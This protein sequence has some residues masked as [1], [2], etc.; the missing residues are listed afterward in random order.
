MPG[1]A[2]M[3]FPELYKK[4]IDS[5]YLAS[6]D[7]VHHLNA[8]EEERNQGR[9]NFEAVVKARERGEHVT[10]LVLLTL[11][12]RTD[13]KVNRESSP[14]GLHGELPDL[15]LH[16]V[17]RQIFRIRGHLSRVGRPGLKVPGWVE[18]R[19][20]RSSRRRGGHGVNHRGRDRSR[21]ALLLERE[22]AWILH[23]RFV[24]RL[25]EGGYNVC[26]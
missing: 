1:F 23:R 5:G 25:R 13:T 14:L 22:A 4:F 8:Y 17:A 3:Q 24:H 18:D 10:D 15:R 19:L 20:V 12:P 16:G 6:L 21:C 2:K 26:A 7:G 11:L 9:L